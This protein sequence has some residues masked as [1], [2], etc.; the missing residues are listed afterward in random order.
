MSALSEARAKAYIK[1]LVR[2]PDA[3]ALNERITIERN[4][5]TPDGAGG[6]TTAWGALGG[7][8]DGKRWAQ[9]LPT[10]GRE[11]LLNEAL[12]GVQGFKVTIRYDRTIR[13]DDRIDWRG[14]LMNIRSAADPDGRKVWTV[15]FADAGVPT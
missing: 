6:F 8:V 11:T 14:T 9:V 2:L 1:E 12:Q 7:A 4:N 15:I 10:G 13:A 3:G 5:Q